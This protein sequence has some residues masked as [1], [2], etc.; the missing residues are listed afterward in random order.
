MKAQ[1][2]SRWPMGAPSLFVG[3]AWLSLWALW[4]S[5]EFAEPVGGASSPRRIRYVASMPGGESAY[6]EPT[7]FV[8]PSRP[9]SAYV[10]L[11]EGD[12]AW[13]G[14]TPRPP[15]FWPRSNAADE[16]R[17]V[18]VPLAERAARDLEGYRLPSGGD[19]TFTLGPS[20]Q[21]R[22]FAEVSDALRDVGFEMQEFPASLRGPFERA[23][24]VAVSVE[25][26]EQGRV[27]HVFLDSGCDRPTVNAAVLR[28]IREG[29][30]PQGE[31]GRR[32]RVALNYG[33]R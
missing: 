28:M 18:G 7:V 30:A 16:A 1:V 25:L 29:R 32:G 5:A 20:R 17:N 2:Y 21:M 26:D 3:V 6:L 23:W 10:G 11:S 14:Q 8:R 19:P 24:R 12:E 13:P 15:R 22:L 4:P 31:P 9:G 27:A 33:T